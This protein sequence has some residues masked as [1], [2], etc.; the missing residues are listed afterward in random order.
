M[1]RIAETYCEGTKANSRLSSLVTTQNCPIKGTKCDGGGNRYASNIVIATSN[2][3]GLVPED[4]ICSSVCSIETGSGENWIVCP[5][6]LFYL[7]NTLPNPPQQKLLSFLIRK[8]GLSGTIGWWKEVK[9][10]SKNANGDSFDYTFD[11]VLAETSSNG[12]KVNSSP[13]ILEV[14]TSS[15]S[16]GNKKKGTTIP[17]AFQSLL[18]SG[19]HTAPGINYRQV[20]GRM[21]SQFFVKSQVAS[22]WGGRTFWLIQDSLLNYITKSTAFDFEKNKAIS[23]DE[24]N[25]VSANFGKDSNQ[26]PNLEPISIKMASGKLSGSLQTGF[27][28]ILG[29]PF[30]PSKSS[31]ISALEKRGP[32]GLINL[33]SSTNR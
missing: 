8:S 13:I 25:L 26:N 16:G 5:R 11:Y 19:N 17:Q 18:V 1:P 3:K 23:A 24:I 7:G 14:M 6:R 15:T 22:S 4:E 20:W 29:T 2:L 21:I 9:I 28:S 32:N 27:M 12:S 31:F 33:N 10:K 30:T